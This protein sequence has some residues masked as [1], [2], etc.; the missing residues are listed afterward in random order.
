ME[1]GGICG[2]GM[3][4]EIQLDFVYRLHMGIGRGTNTKDALLALWGLLWFSYEKD[5]HSLTI[6]GDLKVIVD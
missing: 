6:S 1:Q 4:I 2:A 3:V 5:I